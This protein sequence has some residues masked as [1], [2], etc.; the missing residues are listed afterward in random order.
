MTRG[1]PFGTIGNEV[2]END[3][4]IRQDL[5]LIFE[6]ARAKIATL[7]VK[8]KAGGRLD[9]NVREDQLADF[10]LATIQG[11][12]ADGKSQ[13]RSSQLVESVVHEAT[14]HLKRYAQVSKLRR[15]R[16]ETR[17]ERVLHEQDTIRSPG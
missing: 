11:A 16:G 2:T 8:E 13:K 7:F 5:S 9:P 4:L 15:E 6:V 12:N 3:E 14:A 17:D 10:C 1:Y